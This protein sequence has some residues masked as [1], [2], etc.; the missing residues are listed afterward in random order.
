MIRLDAVGKRYPPGIDA[1]VDVSAE[2][3]D[4]DEPEPAN[5]EEE[6]ETPAATKP[7]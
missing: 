3:A 5:Q 1:L 2:I 7:E 4:G 6:T